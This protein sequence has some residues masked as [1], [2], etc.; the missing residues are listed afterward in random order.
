MTY[1]QQ[2][3]NPK[4][5]LKMISN[6]ELAEI[7]RQLC[8]NYDMCYHDISTATL[9]VWASIIRVAKEIVDRER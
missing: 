3:L 8:D 7:M 5:D 1:M 9:D 6:E 2:M 4:Y